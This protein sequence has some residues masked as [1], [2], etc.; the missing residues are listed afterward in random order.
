MNSSYKEISFGPEAIRY[1]RE[2][3]QDRRTLSRYLLQ[4]TDLDQGRVTTVLPSNVSDESAK[5]FTIGGKLPLPLERSIFHYKDP[6]GK[7]WRVEPTPSSAGVLTTIIQTYLNAGGQRLCLFE[8]EWRQPEYPAI[9]R[10]GT[11]I[12]FFQN[13]V[14][15]VLTERDIDRNIIAQTVKNANGDVIIGVMMPLSKDIVLHYKERAINQEQLQALAVCT[16]KIIIGAYDGEGYL[17]W[18]KKAIEAEGESPQ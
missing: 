11:R 2:S 13:E 1:I 4:N 9:K 7:Q 16:E 3:L 12:L 10:I 15:H 14:Y 8:D 18:S 17:I 5:Q 6:H